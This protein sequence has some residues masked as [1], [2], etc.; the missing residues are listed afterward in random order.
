MQAACNLGF[1]Q[2][3]LLP[4]PLN[5]FLGVDREQFG[6]VEGVSNVYLT[7]YSLRSGPWAIC[8][9]GK[10]FY[11]QFH[12]MESSERAVRSLGFWR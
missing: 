5:V 1:W 8:E 12:C 3:L 2:E 4:I 6:I 10:G 9:L 11:C 7:L